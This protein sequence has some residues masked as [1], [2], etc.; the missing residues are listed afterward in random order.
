VATATVRI[1]GLREL[2]AAFR[3]VEKEL[4]KDLRDELKAAGEVVRPVA[5]SLFSPIDARSAAGYRVR[6]RARGVAVEQSL[7]RTTGQH[8]QYG[9]LQMERA[10]M[11]ALDQKEGEVFDLMDGMLNR[12]GIRAGF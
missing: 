2:N 5:S 1:R 11:P 10:L 8:P 3:K 9:R 7:A 4:R 12:L 6:V